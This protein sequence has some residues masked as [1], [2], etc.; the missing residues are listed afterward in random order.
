KKGHE[1]GYLKVHLFMAFLLLGGFMGETVCRRAA[2]VKFWDG[3]APWYKLWMEHNRYHNRIIEMLTTMIEP[4][5]KVLDI[6]AGNGV[7]SLPLCAI[8]CEVTALEPSV[9]MR[10]LLFEEAMKK[11]VG[12]ID[13]DERCWDDTPCF[14]YQNYDL[15]MACNSLHLAGQGFERSLAKVFNSGARNVFVVTER[16]PEI[17]IPWSHGDY[18]LLFTKSY[19]AESSF[20]YHQM[21]EVWDHH[22]FKKGSRLCPNEEHEIKSQLSFEDD[23]FYIRNTAYVG[24]YWWQRQ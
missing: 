21:A 17:K 1:G 20:V 2:T 11:G 5:W 22:E 6:G 13:I 9:G 10:N 8:G 18:S 4:G 15:F 12:W 19:E 23:H 24:M 7:L 3:Y 14:D 16:L